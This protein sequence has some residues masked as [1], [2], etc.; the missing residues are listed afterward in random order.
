[1]NRLDDLIATLPKKIG[2]TIE[3]PPV[4]IV[5]VDYNSRDGLGEYAHS[6]L[7]T[8]R[9][10]TG[11][12]TYS[13]AHANNLAMMAGSGEYVVLVPADVYLEDG[14]LSSLRDRINQGA[15]WCNTAKKHR[16]TIAI[17]KT[18]FVAAGGY[19][20]RFEMY[21]PDDLD[22]IERLERRGVQ[23]GFIPDELVKDI[24][25]SPEKKVANYRLKGMDHKRLGQ[26]SIPYYLE[27]KAAGALVANPGV[28]WG[29]WQ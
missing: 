20:E 22:L 21:G 6:S 7:F 12:D 1:M 4:E 28:E 29:K 2:A 11:R 16:S 18:E 25:T 3:S 10:Y 24:Y 23:H 19:D 14:Y 26:L 27:N 17:L 5:V 8:Y 9:K 13:A 15:V